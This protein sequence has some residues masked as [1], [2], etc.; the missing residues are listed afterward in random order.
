MPEQKEKERAMDN[1]KKK[2]FLNQL[3]FEAKHYFRNI[4]RNITI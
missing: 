4:I 3:V 2:Y 1:R